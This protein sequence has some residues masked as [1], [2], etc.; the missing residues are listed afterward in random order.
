MPVMIVLR[1]LLRIS[2][3]IATLLGVL[4]FCTIG[5]S[6]FSTFSL[7]RRIRGILTQ[8][9]SIH[10]L[11][12]RVYNS[13]TGRNSEPLAEKIFAKKEFSRISG[14]FPFLG[15]C[16]SPACGFNPHHALVCSLPEGRSTVIRICLSCDGIQFDDEPYSDLPFSWHYGFVS[17]LAECGMPCKPRTPWEFE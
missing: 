10:M 9:E 1:R 4:F 12:Y 13:Q 17:L 16:D 7:A 3:L 5:S 14:A 15:F 8:A 11:E 6:A 2:L